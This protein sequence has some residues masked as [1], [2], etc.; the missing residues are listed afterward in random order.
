LCAVT[1]AAYLPA[2]HGGFIWDDSA[3]L[4]DNPLIK[5]R[6]GL[7]RFWF[8][9]E[10]P[11][12][13][14][15]TSTTL[16]LEWRLW[17]MSPTGYH[18]TN[19]ALHSVEALLLWVVLA[20]LGIGGSYLAALLFAVHPV[21]VESVAW[22]SQRKNLTAMLFFL[23]ATLAHL[24]TEDR[25]PSAS[26]PPSGSRRRGLH[27][28]AVVMFALAMLGKGSAAVLPLVLLLLAWWRRG[29]V[30]RQDLVRIAPFAV[31]AAILVVVNVWFQTHG[32]GNIRDVTLVERVLGAGAVVWFY[33]YKALLPFKLAFVYPLWRIRPDELGW[34][35]PLL[36]AAA[37]S[38]LLAIRFGIFTAGGSDSYGYVSQAALWASERVTVPEPLAPIGHALGIIT[39]PLGYR[40]ASVA[41]ASVP[42]Y[43]PGYPMLMAVATKLAGKA[44]VYYVVPLCAGMAVLMTFLV[45]ARFAGSRTG[46]IA[47]ILLACSPIF[48][49]QSLEPMSDVPVTMWFMIAWWLLLYDGTLPTAGAGLATAAAILTRPNLVLLAPVLGLFALRG[50]QRV[51]RGLWFGLG[52]LPGIA[53]VAMIDRH[54]YG[55]ASMSGYGSLSELFDWRNVVPNLQ[56][57][58]VWLVQLQTPVILVALVAPFVSRREPDAERAIH[59]PRSVAVWMI[60]FGVVLL[61]SYLF[62]GV[63]EDWPYLRFLLPVIPLLLVLGSSVFVTGLF[64]APVAL[65]GAAVF[66]VCVLLGTWYL[67]KADAIGVYAIGFSERR[68]ESVGRYLARA[69][70]PKAAVLTVIESGSVRLYADRAT[71]RWDE[72]PAGKLDV[73]IE[74]L[75]TSGYAPFILLEDWEESMF[76]ARFGRADLAGRVDWPPAIECYGPITVR[77]YDPADRKRYLAGERWL[78]KIVPHM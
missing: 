28:L 69:L 5:A 56:R 47:A 34:W 38:V 13:W 6:G 20:R 42:T 53:A 15:L 24:Q 52:V 25:E 31:V 77:I 44:A 8:T 71:L 48:V 41:G 72:V 75:R 10:P 58:P 55:T 23:L 11:D 19:I 50:K 37:V 30:T 68:Y 65:R 76:R 67:K 29:R 9:T 1:W 74:A 22:I 62:Y 26:D 39:A 7:Y 36:A 51:P 59:D 14:P 73:T 4:I 35:V 40:P 43:A 78:P 63:F 57:Y 70:P 17:G 2:V 21:N 32:A 16:W 60:A 12:Y 54:M 45:G 61:I 46:M 3:L 18:V 66:T 27:V 49:F 33:L 64:H